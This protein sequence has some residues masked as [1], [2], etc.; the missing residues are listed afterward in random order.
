MLLRNRRTGILPV[1]LDG[2]EAYPTPFGDGLEAYPTPFGDG[3]EAYPTP[4]GRATWDRL[5]AYPTP[6][7]PFL[8][9]IGLEAYPTAAPAHSMA[10]TA[11][12]QAICAAAAKPAPSY[13]RPNSP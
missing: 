11:V 9:S 5:E 13:F 12:Q 1:M 8:R 4:F 3:L 10:H 6:F 7:A 2:L